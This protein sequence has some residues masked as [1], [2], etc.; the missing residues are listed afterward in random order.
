MTLPLISE[1][2]GQA[3]APTPTG[4][5]V[6]TGAQSVICAA[7]RSKDGN[8][9]GHTW[10]VRAWWPKG[11]D[12]SEKQQ[13]LRSYLSIFDHTLLADELAWGEALAESI[14][15]GLDA[16]RVEVSRP[17]EGLYA[18]AEIARLTGLEDRGS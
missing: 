1:T 17:H 4:L 14:C 7:H 16:H 18:V 2:E 15:L 8:V 6:W 13:I 10:V 12:A 9:H 3:V 11:P 5:K